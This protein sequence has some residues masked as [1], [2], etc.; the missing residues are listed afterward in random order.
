MKKMIFYLLL[1]CAFSVKSH[2]QWHVTPEIGLTSVKY[3]GVGDKNWTAG[4]KAGVSVEYMLHIDRLSL[5]SGLYYANRGYS[6]G[7]FSEDNSP[8]E[9]SNVYELN[10][11]FLQ[12]PVMVNFYCPLSDEVSLF[13]AAGPYAAISI[14]DKW[15]GGSFKDTGKYGLQDPNAFDWGVS[16]LVGIEINK[17]WVIQ[18]GYDLSLGEESSND[19]INANYH[20]LSL[21]IGYKF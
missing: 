8:Y 7:I 10:R 19:G 6:L 18:A 12:L 17:R 9:V 14:K 5:K 4:V 1:I 21:S 3:N 16:A 2:A 15:E 20:T 11:N 13:F